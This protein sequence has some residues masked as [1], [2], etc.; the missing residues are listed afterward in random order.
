L[1]QSQVIAA[2]TTPVSGFFAETWGREQ[3]KNSITP[4]HSLVCALTINT[5]EAGFEMLRMM[6]T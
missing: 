4:Y 6:N 5:S 1:T 2:K 3:N